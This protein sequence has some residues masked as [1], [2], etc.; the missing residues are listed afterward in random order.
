MLLKRV[1]TL[2]NLPVQIS[3]LPSFLS[4]NC[5]YC[6][7]KIFTAFYYN[8]TRI[9]PMFTA[10]ANHIEG[11]A[12]MNIIVIIRSSKTCMSYS[13]WWY[14]SVIYWQYGWWKS[15]FCG[16]LRRV[17]KYSGLSSQIRTLHMWHNV[18]DNLPS[19]VPMWEL[20]ISST[21]CWSSFTETDIMRRVTY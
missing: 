4:Q 11:T 13:I 5:R 15:K 2:N 19:V 10:S 3:P 20:R 14:V 9:T 6:L 16:M 7:V 17:N 8:A 12:N 21:V 18:T 1:R